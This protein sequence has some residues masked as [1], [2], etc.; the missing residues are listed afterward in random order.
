MVS[1]FGRKPESVETVHIG[2]DQAFDPCDNKAENG[3]AAYNVGLY[4]EKEFQRLVEQ[5]EKAERRRLVSQA[6]N[7][8]APIAAE[9]YTLEMQLGKLMDDAQRQTFRNGDQQ[10]NANVLK[11]GVRVIKEDGMRSLL[12]KTLCWMERHLHDK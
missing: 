12:K 2:V 10:S 8:C 9:V 3:Y 1:N 7:V 5:P 11:K 6:L 4:F